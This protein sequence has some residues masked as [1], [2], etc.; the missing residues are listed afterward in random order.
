[1]NLIVLETSLYLI[2]PW[3]THLTSS[4]I[5]FPKV[6]H[7]KSTILIEEYSKIF[8]AIERASKKTDAVTFH[9]KNLANTLESRSLSHFGPTN[10]DVF[11]G[12]Y[13]IYLYRHT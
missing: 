9:A 11:G 8:L 7:K 12:G 4:Y 6:S 2:F 3:F 10:M 1:M 5:N 13:I